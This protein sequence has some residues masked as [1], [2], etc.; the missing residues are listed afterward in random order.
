[1]EKD[2]AKTLSE[3]PNLS[4]EQIRSIIRSEI[5]NKEKEKQEECNHS[6][7]ADLIDGKKGI[8]KCH[9]CGKVGN[10]NDFGDSPTE[11]PPRMKAQIENKLKNEE[12]KTFN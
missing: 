2:L 6:R 4:E 9:D 8:I 12:K 11:I 5:D 7:S 3:I 1:M 10:K